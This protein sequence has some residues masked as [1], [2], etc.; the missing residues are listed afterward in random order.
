MYYNKLSDLG[1]KLTR[2]SGHLKTKCPKCSDGRKNK[3]DMPL[4]VNINEG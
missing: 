1:I 2:S 4:S 3:T